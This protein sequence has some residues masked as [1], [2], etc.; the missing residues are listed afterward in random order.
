M[1]IELDSS[2]ILINGHEVSFPT[3]KDEL[4]KILGEPTRHYY[5]SNDWRIIWDE[6][7]V[8]ASG[9]DIS[10]I[11]FIVKDQEGFKYTPSHLFEG[12]LIVDGKP[13]QDY[14][15]PAVKVEK[16]QVRQARY[17]GEE[18]QPIFSYTLGKNF[19]YKEQADESKYVLQKIAGEPIVFKDFNFKLAVIEELMYQQGLL[20]PKFDVF[21]FAQLY[22]G[23]KID[24]ANEGYAPIPEAVE[25]FKNLEIDT[26]LADKVTSI[27]QDGG[28]DIYMNIA[29]Q[30]GG[31]DSTFDVKSFDDVAAFPNLKHVTLFRIDEAL[32]ESLKERGI[33]VEEL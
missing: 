23:R 19:D 10:T 24:V 17:R 9:I 33:E 30:W 2:G 16:Y 15:E 12:E 5:D 29:P 21:E 27:E 4:S 13:I 32:T 25:Y 6:L 20:T 28:N 26:E 14:A 11:M 3:T 22:K 1:K 31:D 18:T 7:G 8:Y